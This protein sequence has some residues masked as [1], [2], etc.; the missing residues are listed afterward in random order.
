[1]KKFLVEISNKYQ[2][3]RLSERKV[4]DAILE[5]NINILDYTIEEF[6][7]LVGVSQPTIIRF[8]NAMGLNGYK[9]LKKRLIQEQAIE[10]INLKSEYTLDYPIQAQDKLIDIPAKIIMTNIKHLEEALK[11]LSMYEFVNAVKALH[12]AEHI[13]VYAVENSVCTAEDFVTKMAYIGK[14]VFFN[15]DGYMQK[16]NALGLKPKDVA[17][18]I[19]HTGKST[20]TVKA[21]QA[22][23]QAGATTIAI[24]NF[25]DTIINKYADIILCTGNKQY[26]Y[27]NAI[28]SRCAQ[29]TFVDMLYLGLFLLDYEENS[30]KLNKSWE[31]IQDLIYE[32]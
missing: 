13:S 23:K 2:E 3:L 15:K 18:G 30:Y 10:P 6:A 31:N 14:Q 1:M 17:V 19:S 32:K 21:L 16:V 7:K 20:Y 28:F 26:M 4:A 27:G 11:N 8:A 24:T 12:Q 5:K 22:A 9:G 29:I 25:A